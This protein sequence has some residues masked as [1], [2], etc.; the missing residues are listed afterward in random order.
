MSPPREGPVAVLGAGEE[1]PDQYPEGFSNVDAQ[2]LRR[3]DLAFPE[4]QAR[5]FQDWKMYAGCGA[6][7]ASRF[8]AFPASLEFPLID[9]GI[10]PI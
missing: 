1:L 3:G 10:L 2:G 7:D 6:R 8:G 4:R 9:E 5:R